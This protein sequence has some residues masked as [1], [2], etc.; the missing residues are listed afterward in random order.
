MPWREWWFW[1]LVAP[2]AGVLVVLAAWTVIKLLDR[3]KL[4]GEMARH[5]IAIRP[6]A[7]VLTY[8]RIGA[9][10]PDVSQLMRATTGVVMLGRRPSR[11]PVV[12]VCSKEDWEAAKAVG[13]E[14]F[15][16]MPWPAYMVELVPSQSE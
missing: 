11:T 2:E 15:L 3:A 5:P 14:P 16:T 4:A 12:W 9:M 6:G 10:H 7:L 1:V 13:G 8:N